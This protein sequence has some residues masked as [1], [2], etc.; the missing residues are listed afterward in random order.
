VYKQFVAA[1]LPR[2]QL[3]REAQRLRVQ[4]TERAKKERH[5]V[6]RAHTRKENTHDSRF[7]RLSHVQ[8][9]GRHHQRQL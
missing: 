4:L 3:T 8:V 9:Y 7:N 6:V 1:E 2:K 5:K